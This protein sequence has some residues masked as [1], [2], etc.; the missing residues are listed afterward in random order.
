MATAEKIIDA[1]RVTD[2]NVE[3]LRE[4]NSGRINDNN[5]IAECIVQDF[6]H[7]KENAGEA[8]SKCSFIDKLLFIYKA[9]MDRGYALA[10]I[11]VQKVQEIELSE[12]K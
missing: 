1:L 11:D 10:L 6:D 4:Y 5:L 8:F 9:A 7:Y 12:L 3:E 2:T